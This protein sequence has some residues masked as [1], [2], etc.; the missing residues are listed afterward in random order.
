MHRSP[1]L[2][3]L[4]DQMKSYIFLFFL[5]LVLVGCATALETYNLEGNTG[6]LVWDPSRGVVDGYVVYWGTDRNNLANR[7]DVG[8]IF[9]YR[10]DNF[11]FS[12]GVTYYIS[13]SAYNSAGESPLCTPIAVYIE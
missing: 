7:V 13:V 8:P 6:T 4:E 10:L 1:L 12:A 3:K 5:C 11:P 2:Y 9:D